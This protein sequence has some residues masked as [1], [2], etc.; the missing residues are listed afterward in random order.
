MTADEPRQRQA[1]L[2]AGCKDDPAVARH[3]FEARG[4]LLP[5]APAS[6]EQLATLIRLPERYGVIFQALGQPPRLQAELQ[7]VEA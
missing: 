4:T 6:D 1:P 5:D 7:R 2:E 3:T